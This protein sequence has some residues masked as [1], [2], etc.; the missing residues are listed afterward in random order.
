[1]GSRVQR[2]MGPSYDEFAL[3]Q[4]INR[5]LIVVNKLNAHCFGFPISVKWRYLRDRKFACIVISVTGL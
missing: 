2:S 3:I 4:G 1:M 5:L